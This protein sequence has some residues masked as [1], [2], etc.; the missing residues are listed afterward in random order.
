MPVIIQFDRILPQFLHKTTEQISGI[1]ARY[2]TSLRSILEKKIQDSL[3]ENNFKGL[4]QF[5]EHF[6]VGQEFLYQ[7]ADD[8]TSTI[9][10]NRTRAARFLMDN[11]QHILTISCVNKLRKVA[12]ESTCI[13][14]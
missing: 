13:L 4:A 11:F 2:H 3:L 14:Q 9:T 10:P 12:T 5:F 6:Y 8:Y 7:L 1:D